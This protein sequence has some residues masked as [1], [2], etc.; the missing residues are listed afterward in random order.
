MALNAPIQSRDPISTGGGSGQVGRKFLS[1]IR[2][3][4]RA[5]EGF[6]PFPV[7]P[8][9]LPWTL[10]YYYARES[11]GAGPLPFESLTLTFTPTPTPD[12]SPPHTPQTS[13]TYNPTPVL[14]CYMMMRCS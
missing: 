7:P 11:L 10:P 1:A 2:P 9:A 6:F 13:A 4:S 14:L 3:V 12:F 8:R 5:L